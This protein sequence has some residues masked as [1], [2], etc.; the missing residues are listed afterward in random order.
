MIIDGKN[1]YNDFYCDL[2]IVG[3][4]TVGLFLANQLKKSYKRIIIIEK[5][6]FFLKKKKNFFKNI[7]YSHKGS[8]YSYN[9][10]GGT[11][12][13][14]GGQLVEFLKKDFDSCYNWG[15]SYEEIKNYYEKIYKIFK[16]KK[17]DVNLCKKQR[18]YPESKDLKLHFSNW[19]SNPNFSEVFKEDFNHQSIKILTNVEAYEFE[20]INN[21]AT[22]IFIRNKLNQSFSINSKIYILAGGTVAINQLLLTN[23]ELYNVPWNKNNYLGSY[24]QDHLGLFAADV[25]LINEN[26]FRFFFENGFY[27]GAKYQPKLTSNYNLKNFSLGMSGEFK[28]FSQKEN[29]T[30]IKKM[31]RNFLNNKNVNNLLNLIKLSPHN[32]FTNVISLT[33][34]IKNK[35]IMAQFDK[36][37][38]F[39]VQSEQVPLF[40]SKIKVSSSKNKFTNKLLNVDI[41]WQ[42]DGKEFEYIN[43][44]L[45]SVNKYLLKHKIAYLKSYQKNNFLNIRDTNHPS[46]GTIISS[47]KYNGVVDSNLKIW[48][49]NNIYVA[50]SSVFPK[51]SFAN[52]TLTILAFSLRLSKYLKK[53]KNII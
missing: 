11:S 40:K 43:I 7:S 14:W 6:D 1:I 20:F 9:G 36:A 27:K 21:S 25:N 35:R 37:L 3:G 28:F 46:G 49:T 29:L 19:F 2:V 17:V 15:V 30:L 42:I 22:R 34:L 12:K 32:L 38:K 51:N 23:K 33:H 44:F 18:G 4:G 31:A 52:N 53:N 50:S 26:K 10:V 16:V 8:S 5:G 41:D 45:S 47:N 39:Y 13:I 48:G 24:F